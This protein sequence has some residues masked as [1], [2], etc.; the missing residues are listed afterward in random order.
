MLFLMILGALLFLF[1]SESAYPAAPQRMLSTTSITLIVVLGLFTVAII[2]RIETNELINLVSQKDA[3]KINWDM[4]FIL[5]AVTLLI[6]PLI[7]IVGH[8]FPE[9]GDWLQKLA[10]P[11]SRV[12]K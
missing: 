10:D 8:W 1:A 5:Q 7:V 4:A 6:V 12:V 3:G 11:I 9:A 2:Y